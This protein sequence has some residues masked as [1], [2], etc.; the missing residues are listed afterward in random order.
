[1]REN[2]LLVDT[3]GSGNSGWFYLIEDGQGCHLS[4]ERRGREES[5]AVPPP[6]SAG[7]IIED[8]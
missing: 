2:K 7:R 4:G 8:D 6:F 3:S 5:T 1:M